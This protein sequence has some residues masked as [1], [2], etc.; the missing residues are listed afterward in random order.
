MAFIR[1]G[2]EIDAYRAASVNGWSTYP[3]N[4]GKYYSVYA[5]WAG[6]NAEVTSDNAGDENELIATMSA[7]VA[8]TDPTAMN[9]TT[10]S[11][12]GNLIYEG[13]MGVDYDG[14]PQLMLAEDLE[15]VSETE[16]V[17]TLR[18]G[19]QFH[20]SDEYDFDGREMTAEDVKFSWE[21]YLGTTREA[22]VGDWLGV[23]DTPEGEQPESFEGNLTVE[24]DYTLRVELPEV[25]APFQ[26][27]VGAA[28]VVPREAGED[29]PLDLSQEPIGTG[30]Y[31]FDQYDPDELYRI[32]RFE[33]HW[34]DGSNGVPET[35][36]IETVT[37]RIITE[38]SAREAALRGGDVDLA[39]P[40]QGSV[41]ALQDESDFTVTSRIAGG[42]DMLIYPMNADTPFQN[43]KVRLA[44]NRL[45]DREGIIEAVYNGIGTPAYSPISPL[46]GSFTSEEFNQRM[47]NEYSR[48]YQ[49]Q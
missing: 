18:E 47:G 5:P 42:F 2:E 33:D 24:G 10:S 35:P 39:Q 3:I 26:F 32:K 7:D 21:R 6:Q 48:Y 40:P 8:N 12:S 31:Q 49:R 4:G 27:S 38:S 9:D 29:G 37:F 1:Y 19:V 30:P 16:Y 36:P 44:V 11:M 45:I 25:Y 13:V 22:D 17:F 20:A 23:P 46:A 34:H 14:N 41:S 28:L 43:E 15:Q